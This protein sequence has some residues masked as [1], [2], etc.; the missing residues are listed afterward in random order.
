MNN[1]KAIVKGEDKLVNEVKSIVE[2]GNLPLAVKN[3]ISS[4]MVKAVI[5]DVNKADALPHVKQWLFHL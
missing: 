5:Y 3:G 1:F 4:D 2:K